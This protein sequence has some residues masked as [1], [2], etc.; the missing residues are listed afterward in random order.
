MLL[1]LGCDLLGHVLSF[2]SHRALD[3]CAK[4][5]TALLLASSSS[6]HQLCAKDSGMWDS[7]IDKLQLDEHT[8]CTCLTPVDKPRMKSAELIRH[9]MGWDH[10]EKY[11]A[12]FLYSHNDKIRKAFMCDCRGCFH[13][14][15][16]P[17][18]RGLSGVL[19]E[20]EQS[21]IAKHFQ[22]TWWD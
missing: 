10:D 2:A 19:T 6:I 12:R 8:R 14:N 9:V 5:C 4:S 3:N 22:V 13:E 16:L 7:I 17:C 15:L 18:G 21:Q 20:T 11:R 1:S